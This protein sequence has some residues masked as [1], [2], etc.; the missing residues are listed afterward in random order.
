MSRAVA[1]K[2]QCPVENMVELLHPPVLLISGG[3][4]DLGLLRIGLGLRSFYW[5]LGVDAE[6]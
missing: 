2:S 3:L 4:T 5:S 6:I 1:P